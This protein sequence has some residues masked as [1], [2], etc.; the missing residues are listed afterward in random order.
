MV[1]HGAGYTVYER[2]SHGLRQRLTVFV[3]TDAPVKIV[4]LTLTNRLPRPRR[5]T[6]TYYAEWVLGPMREEQQHHVV[7][8]FDTAARCLLARSGWTADFGERV[9]FLSGDREPHGF[10][11]DRTEFLG[12][13]GSYAKPEALGRWGLSGTADGGSDPC[14]VLQTHL[15]LAPGE[16]LDVHFVLGQGRDKAHAVE[17][18]ARFRPAVEVEASWLAL[19]AHWDGVLGAVQVKTPEPAMDLMLNRWLLYQSLSSRLL[20]RTAFY[21]ASGAYGYRDQLQGRDGFDPRRTAV[22]A[23]PHPR[24][25]SAPVPGRGRPSLVAPAG[26]SRRAHPLLG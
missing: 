9:A 2:E 8:E 1:R 7:C 19:H 14:A 26:G 3:P 23:R 18:A 20:A 10:T 17:L 6:A 24:R 13:S 4:R 15:E 5:L 11:A 22:D 16:S 25:S 12:R 21:Q